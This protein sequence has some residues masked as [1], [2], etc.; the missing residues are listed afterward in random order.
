MTMRHLL[1]RDLSVA[2]QNED[3]GEESRSRARG[4]EEEG[5]GSGESRGAGRAG[6]LGWRP[7]YCLDVCRLV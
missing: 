3:E 4:G 7:N 2:A 6:F 5:R 1:Y